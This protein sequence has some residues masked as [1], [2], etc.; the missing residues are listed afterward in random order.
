[1]GT[2][3]VQKQK[4]KRGR[5]VTYSVSN[6]NGCIKDH[7]IVCAPKFTPAIQVMLEMYFIIKILKQFLFCN[8]ALFYS[9]ISTKRNPK[10]GGKKI[11]K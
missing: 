6:K 2:N 5:L 4:A 7:E 9:I 8:F 10:G 1:M 11:Y 3:F